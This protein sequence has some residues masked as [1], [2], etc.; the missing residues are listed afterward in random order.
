MLLLSEYLKDLTPLLD[1][2]FAFVIFPFLGF[3]PAPPP[4]LRELDF[5]CIESVC[6]SFLAPEL[7]GVVGLSLCFT[8]P[9]TRK[10]Q[11]V[12]SCFVHGCL[13]SLTPR[14]ILPDSRI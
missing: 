6:A 4:S 7:P 9:G 13:D 3:F 11:T 14:C 12:L 1:S 5:R 2:P 8:V 10:N